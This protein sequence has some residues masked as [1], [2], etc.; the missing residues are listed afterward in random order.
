MMLLN[1][2]D[3][4][5]SLE[6]LVVGIANSNGGIP[7]LKDV[8]DPKSRSH[9]LS[10]TYPLESDM[11]NELD[12]FVSILISYGINVHRP[13]L[14]K[15]YNQIYSRD[16]GFVVENKFF[17]SNILPIRSREIDA[18]K[19]ILNSFDPELIIA[20]PKDAHIE[21]GD[22]VLHKNKIYIGA[23]IGSDYSKYITARTNLEGLKF[24]ENYFPK[25][26]V[27]LL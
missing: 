2:V 26:K 21:G 12:C 4:I 9:V 16:I 25:K 3:E 18:L 27:D 11:V 1:I 10:G 24:L 14:I 7:E 5:S 15:N 13:D 20:F 23:Y 6:S 17:K 19:N 8:Y 22:V